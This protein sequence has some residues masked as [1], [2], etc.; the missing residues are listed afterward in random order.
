MRE[1]CVSYAWAMRELCV[2]Y[3]C[4]A[5]YGLAPRGHYRPKR[6]QGERG[7]EEGAEDSMHTAGTTPTEKARRTPRQGG[8]NLRATPR[9]NVPEPLRQ[10][11]HK[12]PATSRA[13]KE[14]VGGG[15]GVRQAHRGAADRGSRMGRGPWQRARS[16][17]D[18]GGR[19]TG[20]A[21]QGRRMRRGP[22]HLP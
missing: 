3:L 8:R 2:S 15:V 9:T 13:P 19:G 6:D 16:L 17:T 4:V 1:L 12:A 20:G 7:E 18:G 22:D 10:S 11:V 14:H 5:T 21:R